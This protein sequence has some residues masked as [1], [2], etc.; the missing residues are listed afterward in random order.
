MIQKDEFYKSH[1]R[2][3]IVDVRREAEDD[4]RVVRV[5][6]AVSNVDVHIDLV[7]V[8]FDQHSGKINEKRK[9]RLAPVMHTSP[10]KGAVTRWKSLLLTRSR[11]SVRQLLQS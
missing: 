3:H 4:L 5:V 9:K 1:L 11:L 10:H 2:F 7:F 6:F 8:C